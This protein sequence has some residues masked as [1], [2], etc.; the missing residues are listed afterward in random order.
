MGIPRRNSD[1]LA[2]A[3]AL[4]SWM[5]WDWSKYPHSAATCA[6]RAPRASAPGGP[7]PSRYGLLGELP[8]PFCVTALI[9]RLNR[10]NMAAFLGGSPMQVRNCWIRWRW[11]HPASAASDPAGVC[12][13][14]LTNLFHARSIWG[15]IAYRATRLPINLSIASNR[16]A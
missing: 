7:D 16:S 6:Q 3:N 2:P 13:Q 11:L 4:N 8:D 12:P 10:S 9:E 14:V 15:G 1:G 5:K